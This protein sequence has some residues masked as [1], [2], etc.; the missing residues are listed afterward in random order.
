[1]MAPENL[2]GKT[3]AGKYLLKRLLGSGS[4]G[5]VYEGVHVD[6]GKRL[7]VKM[8]NAEFADTPE[9]VK[10]FR[11][12][13]RAAS[14]I[15]SDYIVQVF[16]AGQ[17]PE[18]G[19]YMITELL[20]GEDLDAKLS[21]EGRLDVTL[22]ARLGY[23]V[24]RGLAKAHAAGIIHR[25]LKPA[26]IFL[27]MRD[28]DTPLAKILDF[29]ISK[30]TLD[31]GP[32]SRSIDLSITQAGIAIGTPQYMSPEQAQA[33]AI[34]ARTDIW[35]LGTVLYEMLS[36]RP[37]ISDRGSMFDIMVAVVRE[38]VPSIRKIAP[39]VPVALAE[40]V[41][42]AL[43][44]DREKRIGDAGVFAQR[45][46]AA[47]PEIGG[48]TTGRMSVVDAAAPAVTL[49]DDVPAYVVDSRAAFAP[50]ATAAAAAAADAPTEAPP[51]MSV[52]D[53]D[54]PVTVVLDAPS[55]AP[56]ATVRDAIAVA[57]EMPPESTHEP[58]SAPNLGSD[59]P[60]PPSPDSEEPPSSQADR[61]EVFKRLPFGAKKS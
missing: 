22:A 60:P 12:E 32:G 2:V 17:D 34:D 38:E 40:V 46:V 45:L 61:V 44:K 28:D 48:G 26:N 9:V 23:Q 10:R 30:V 15:E 53:D 3:L 1:M 50:T 33:Q 21:R 39:W 54:I 59:P 58:P 13:A 43:V 56:P 24:A 36:G 18:L 47:V 31:D 35:S 11:R 8:M 55:T 14:A 49:A 57:S 25:D 6:I 41:H 19:V 20:M 4:M 27:T 7:A 52:A 16:D 51:P 42:A 5:T 29:G 37:A